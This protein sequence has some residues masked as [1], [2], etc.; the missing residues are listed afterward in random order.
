MHVLSLNKKAIEFNMSVFCSKTLIFAL[1]CRKC[2]LRGP[3]L[4]NSWE[5]GGSMHPDSLETG[6]NLLAVFA[7]YSKPYW[8]PQTTHDYIQHKQK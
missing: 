8:S 2:I 5:E 7:R 3:D 1:E 6:V 4:K